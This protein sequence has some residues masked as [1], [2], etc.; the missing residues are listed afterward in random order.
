MN[1][2]HP[3]QGGNLTFSYLEYDQR[4]VPQIFPQFLIPLLHIPVRIRRGPELCQP[5]FP[6]LPA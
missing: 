4:A 6:V 5:A 1:R 3:H 2:L